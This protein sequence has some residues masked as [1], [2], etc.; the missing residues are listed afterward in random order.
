MQDELLKKLSKKMVAQPDNYMESFRK[1]LLTYVEHKDISISDIAE[2]S[3]LSIET[4]KTLMY[5]KGT[6]CK[7]S[8]AVSIARALHISVDEIVGCGTISPTMCESIQITRNLPD[9]FVHF[10]R[11]AIRYHERMLKEKKASIKAINVMLAE[12]SR[13][14]NLS[15]NNNFELMDISN[16]EDYIRYK[17]F[18]GIKIPCEH[19]M[20][21]LNEGDILL[22]ANDRNPLQNETVVVVTKGFIRIV[23]RKEE[24]LSDGTK[25]ASYYS[26]RNGQFL[27]DETDVEEI[28]GYVAKTVHE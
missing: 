8:T 14:G 1:N 10:V 12:C 16:I 19:Y 11:W 3:G 2:E 24:K 27:A 21:V 7:L 4:I 22:L 18:M 15:M 25:K 28:I 5:G 6:D 13:N 17:V 20:P 23:K 26:I 9:N